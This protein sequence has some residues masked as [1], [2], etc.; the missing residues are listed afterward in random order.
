[1]FRAFLFLSFPHFL[2]LMYAL[3]GLCFAFFCPVAYS[4]ISIP[5][6]RISCGGRSQRCLLS[7]LSCCPFPIMCSFATTLRPLLLDFSKPRSCQDAH[8]IFFF[9]LLLLQIIKTPLG[10]LGNRCVLRTFSASCRCRQPMR[11]Y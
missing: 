3:L 8:S 1:M 5:W 4:V 10:R 9:L 2:L 6:T 7:A 11:N